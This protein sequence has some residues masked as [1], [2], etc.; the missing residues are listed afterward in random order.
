MA[1]SPA[2]HSAAHSAGATHV[3]HHRACDIVEASVIGIVSV[4]DYAYLAVAG[5]T[6]HHRS[7]LEARVVH[8]GTAARNI[9]AT[10]DHRVSEPP[11][12]HSRLDRKVD[13]HLLF[14]VVYSGEESLI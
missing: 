3:L 5:K 10:S 12:H 8:V 7:G 4:Q 14:A 1:A 2:A 6:S 13:D 11:V 9:M